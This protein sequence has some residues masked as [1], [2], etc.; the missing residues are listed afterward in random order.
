MAGSSLW[1]VPPPGSAIS[2][3]LADLIIS[4]SAD[5]ARSS[6]SDDESQPP[7]LTL[8]PPHMTLASNVEPSTYG[9]DPQA[10]LDSIPLLKSS[11]TEVA[12]TGLRSEDFF[13]RRC[14]IR[15][16]FNG[17]RD[18]AAAA[19]A[20]GVEGEGE[21]IAGGRIGEKT[22]RWLEE[23]TGSFGPHVSLI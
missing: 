1:L 16:A 12:F 3:K 10:W 13:F 14:Y 2:K 20:S 15:V 4:V 18:L 21:A 8:F 6:S 5:L 23:W 17:V 19:R 11:P 22:A 9:S 7:S